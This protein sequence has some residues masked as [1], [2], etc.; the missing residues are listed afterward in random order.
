V[1]ASV[2]PPTSSATPRERIAALG[3]SL[4]EDG[5][6]CFVGVGVP[7]S[8]ALLAKRTHA[9][10]AVL[11]YESGMIDAHPPRAPRSIADGSLFDTARFVVPMAELFAYWLQAGR[12]DVGFLGAAQI[13]RIG[14]VNSTVIGDYDRP[15]VRLPGGGGAPE[16][17][18]SA[19][20]AVVL[21]EHSPRTLVRA[22]DFIT[23]VG[24]VGPDPARAQLG[25]RGR[26][27]LRIVTDL[28]LLELDPEAGEFVLR[29]AYEGVEVSE[30]R[31]RTGWDLRVAPT[32]DIVPLPT[33][34][35]IGLLREIG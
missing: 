27:P 7:G 6:V 2:R 35:Q 14:N 19:R 32:I 31:E 25:L 30:V 5:Q 34:E 28:G 3:A 11:V 15:R 18:G 12:I 10:R 20:E 22:V 21:V 9:P 24:R 29:A 26:G 1:N 16:I 8:A 23:T 33:S 4:V 13:D 17:A